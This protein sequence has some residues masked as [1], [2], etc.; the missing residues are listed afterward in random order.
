MES[1]NLKPFRGE[2][3]PEN[4]YCLHRAILLYRGYSPNS[5]IDAN[6]SRLKRIR[7]NLH[8]LERLKEKF[9]NFDI[10]KIAR[11]A[12]LNLH[13]YKKKGTY[14]MVA[15]SETDFDKSISIECKNDPLSSNKILFSFQTLTTRQKSKLDEKTF[16]QVLSDHGVNL[17]EDFF[18]FSQENYFRNK[19]G[20]GLSFY[21]NSDKL[22]D[23]RLVYQSFDSKLKIIISKESSK[24]KKIPLSEKVLIMKDYIQKYFCEKTVGCGYSSNRKENTV[25]H[26]KTCSAEPIY[27]YK[28]TKFPLE[29]STKDELLELGIELDFKFLAWDIECLNNGDS[30]S[31]GSSKSFGS[32]EL[33]SI[34]LYGENCSKVFLNDKNTALEDFLHEVEEIQCEY[35]EKKSNKVKE[36]M[37]DLRIKLEIKN[38]A[39]SL[40]TKYRRHLNYLT[41]MLP[42]AYTAPQPQLTWGKSIATVRP[43]LQQGLD[44]GTLWS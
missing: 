3:D 28:E 5:S 33:L 44:L 25:R 21:E 24:K 6:K 27:D 4:R 17:T 8:Q 31:F 10:D 12:K 23:S 14:E 19:Y 32:Q 22:S 9:P 30:F 40:K 26:M 2:N 43:K 1:T 42:C 34:A 29:D 13:F 41:N 37:E 20:F 7:A 38:L 16:K 39:P 11:H 35:Y 36:Y 15:Q 18:E